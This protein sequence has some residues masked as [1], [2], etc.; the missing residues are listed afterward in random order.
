MRQTSTF[1]IATVLNL[2]F[3]CLLSCASPGPQKR[4]PPG[5]GASSA[6]ATVTLAS[7]N[8]RNLFDAV[9]ESYQDEVLSESQYRSKLQALA[10]VVDTLG[11][12]FLALQ[13]VEN[14]T[15]LRDLNA[16]LARPY[17]QIG[18]LEGNDKQRGIDVAFLSRLPISLVK[19]HADDDLPDRPG[20]SKNY[21]FSRDCLEV[22]LES[23][24]STTILINH[25][26][27]QLGG[28][29]T[30]ATKRRVQ[31]E[32]VQQIAGAVAQ[33]R[34]EGIEVVM[35]DLNDRPGSWS[36]QP[37][38]E[39]L[40]DVFSGW[41]DAMRGTHRSKHGATPLDHILLSRDA[42]P[43]MV[44]A[45]IWKD[46]GR[47]TSDHDPVSVVLRL[48]AQGSEPVEVKTWTEKS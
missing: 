39:N 14:L 42:Q 24:P 43:R 13:E 17:P 12:D 11:A 45:K 15:C 20:V 33:A 48:D 44:T 2:V 18:L 8:V 36:L 22:V 35:G 9:D 10:S 1:F 41:P 25:F 21:R 3:G 38:E 7:W 28:S 31:A 4:P 19:S 27:S 46:A 6:G 26:K 40:F 37:L 30:S 5:I 16:Q 29:K 34:P 23:A 47:Q 32:A